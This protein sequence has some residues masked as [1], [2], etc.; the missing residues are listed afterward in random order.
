MKT[1]FVCVKPKSVHAKD[2]FINNMD[3]LHSC[4]V[5]NRSE[6][7]VVLTSITNR[8]SFE[9]RE[10]GDDNWEVIK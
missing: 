1:E 4:K 9:M 3:K 6:G 10:G 7:K 2:R 5:V 8:Y